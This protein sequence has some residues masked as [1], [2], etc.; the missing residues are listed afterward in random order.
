[1]GCWHDLLRWGLCQPTFE[2][3]IT[4]YSCRGTDA[5]A[6]SRV[7]EDKSAATP[8]NAAE[9]HA[10]GRAAAT[11]PE[12][13]QTAVRQSSKQSEPAPLCSKQE[14]LLKSICS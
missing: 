12:P 8:G 6:A 5:E 9:P 13:V 1:M 14:L 3:D 4:F 2:R 11:Q 10:P 7:S